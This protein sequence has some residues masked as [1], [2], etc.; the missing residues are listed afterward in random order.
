MREIENDQNVDRTNPSPRGT[1]VTHRSEFS[2][3]NLQRKREKKRGNV[4]N[5]EERERREGEVCRMII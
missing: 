3:H 1:V 5:R 2:L 4:H